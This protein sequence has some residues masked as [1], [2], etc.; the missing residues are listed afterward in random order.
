MQEEE[1]E[2]LRNRLVDLEAE[3]FQ[4]RLNEQE[5]QNSARDTKT[6]WL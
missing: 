4:L 5:K 1:I 3:I 2:K 6:V